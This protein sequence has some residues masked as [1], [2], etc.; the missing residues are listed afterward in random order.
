MLP[1]ILYRK[2][3]GQQLSVHGQGVNGWW[4]KLIF[5]FRIYCPGVLVLLCVCVRWGCLT[6]GAE[7]GYMKELQDSK[8]PTQ[9]SA[10][11]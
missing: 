11:D 3:P 2:T 7:A 1:D 5:I 8:Q 4:L 6:G 10:F 9:R